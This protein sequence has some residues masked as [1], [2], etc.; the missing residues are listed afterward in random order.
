M[1]Q[2]AQTF[3]Q[4]VSNSNPN[5]LSAVAKRNEKPKRRLKLSEGPQGKSQKERHPRVIEVD[6]M[7]EQEDEDRAEALAT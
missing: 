1:Q 2:M 6:T 5:L 3:D 7:A 4:M